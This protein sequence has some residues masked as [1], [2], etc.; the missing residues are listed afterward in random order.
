MTN[1]Q[2]L[3]IE[4]KDHLVSGQNNARNDMEQ[5]VVNHTWNAGRVLDEYLIR[6]KPRN[7]S[8]GQFAAKLSKDLK[9]PINFFYF[10]VKFYRLYS[11]QPKKT[12]MTVSHYRILTRV[13]NPQ[14]R[15]RLEDK[16]VKDRLSR[17]DLSMIVRERLR[18][19]RQINLGQDPKNQLVHLNELRGNLY[20]Y[21]IVT[22]TT[23]PIEPEA[24]LVDIGFGILRKIKETQAR[25]IQGGCFVRTEKEEGQYALKLTQ[26]K[27]E[28]IY[29]Y[30][31]FLDRVVDGDTLVMHIDCG[32]DNW[33]TERLRLR[34]INTPEMRSTQ[35]HKAKRFVENAL[36]G[37]K[38]VIVKT[39]KEDKY[40]RYLA[41]IFYLPDEDDPHAVAK[42]GKFLN[43]D[44]L[45]QG[46]ASLYA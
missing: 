23:F 13:D 29:T 38:F 32:F 6:D 24:K 25:S 39:Y 10:A 35:G 21:R 28:N 9:R 17:N 19:K 26:T 2:H 46:L 33:K 18:T 5:Q 22:N 45:D 41:D 40:G 1:Y 8:N 30:L 11:Q 15:K 37:V 31:G 43:Q 16:V 44:L 3:L 42:E 14:E 27:K 34:G 4:L 36:N 7:K 12:G 20:Q